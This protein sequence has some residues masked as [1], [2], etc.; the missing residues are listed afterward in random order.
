MKKQVVERIK[1][2]WRDF[3]ICLV[4]SVFVGLVIGYFSISWFKF[5]LL[6]YTVIF[7]GTT[8][9]LYKFLIKED[10][11]PEHS[12]INDGDDCFPPG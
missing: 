1:I 9:S 2:D 6:G 3:F 12:P 10:D 5:G 8:I 7:L 4:I 11:G